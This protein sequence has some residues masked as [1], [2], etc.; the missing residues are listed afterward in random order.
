M[1][2]ACRPAFLTGK[3]PDPFVKCYIV[4]TV[5]HV[6]QYKFCIFLQAMFHPMLFAE[7]KESSQRRRFDSRCS[8]LCFFTEGSVCWGKE[9]QEVI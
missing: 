4:S 8:L 2:H 9:Q 1:D 7:S 5:L 3:F 6:Q